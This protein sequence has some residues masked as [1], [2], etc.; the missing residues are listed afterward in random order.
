MAVM[1]TEKSGSTRNSLAPLGTRRLMLSR[2]TSWGTGRSD[3]QSK[4]GVRPP[5]LLVCQTVPVAIGS[6]FFSLLIEWD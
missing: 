6:G 4:E 5:R 2:I 1:D 3:V